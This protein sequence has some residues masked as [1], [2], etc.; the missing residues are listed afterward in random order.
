MHYC[1]PDTFSNHDALANMNSH[2][3]SCKLKIVLKFNLAW[4][5]VLNLCLFAFLSRKEK[6]FPMERFETAMF[7]P[8]N[9]L[10]RQNTRE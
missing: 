1:D 5:F 9:G 7:C 10:T 4:I 6:I 2:P 3:S 8:V